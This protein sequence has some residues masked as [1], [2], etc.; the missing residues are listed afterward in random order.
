MKR[1]LIPT[2][3]K[4][5]G[6]ILVHSGRITPEQLT[7]YL[8]MQRE[9]SKPLGAILVE[10]GVLSP[11]DLAN[12]LGE[13]LGIPH[14]WLR[15]GLVDPR[16]VHVLPK[17]K[18]LDYQ[19]IPM[20]RVHNMLT[21]ATAD[22]HG[23]FVFDEIAKMTG[24][25]ILP[26]L[27]RA[28]DIIEAIHDA[29]R[30]D[31]SI[32]ELMASAEETG[33]EVVAAAEDRGIA[34][35]AEMAE[36]SPVINLTN[37]VLLRAIRDG[38]SD[39]HIEPQPGKFQ[40]RIRIDGVLYE[41][42]SPK[43]EMHP[44]VVSR[45]KVMANLDIA[46]RRI[47]Q[48]GRFQVNV[49]GRTI[50]LRFS[51]MP[52]IHG[53]K[54]V[55]RILDRGRALLDINSLGIGEEMLEEF[56][57]L[58]RKPHGLILTCGPT[59]SGKTTTLYA[60]VSML[61]SSEKNIITIEDPVEYQLKNINQNQV[62]E[63]IGLTYA[64]FLKHALRQDPDIILVGEIRDRET[65]EIVIQASLTGHLVLSTL[66]TNDSASAITR[67]LEMGV[68]PYLI[69]SALTAVIAQRLLRSICPECKTP[70]YPP[71]EV[72]RE[73]GFD[74]EKQLRLLKGKG[75]SACYDSGFKGRLGL[76]EMLE[77]DDG[78]QRLILSSGT[79]DDYQRYLK[80]KGH[81]TLRE[82]GY[83]KVLKGLTTIEEVKRATSME[84]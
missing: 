33:I 71:R 73:L 45:L 42:M 34:E 64:K 6:E 65:A 43:L 8:R 1:T 2:K 44:A 49:D 37:L 40:I 9:T 81:K 74:E 69:S 48:D 46:E 21:L 41:L 75:C 22:P 53:E 77:M 39:V 52:G 72:I 13:Q 25:E 70:F 32:E 62:K 67:L 56:K 18:A 17:D 29:Y 79:V 12:A 35:I 83:E 60:A 68:E 36:G 16:I 61:N 23:I 57:R 7:E 38:A 82:S 20:F 26:V 11:E 47:P 63:T 15:K 76:Y 5:L 66:H 19:V 24:L 58:L 28:N 84:F 50:D 10:R 14:V 27:C 80:T 78:L 30:E 55:L 59:G 31:I 54:V 51:S 3:R 4:M